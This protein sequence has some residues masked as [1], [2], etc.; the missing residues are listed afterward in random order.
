[1]RSMWAVPKGADHDRVLLCI[2][3]G[4]YIAGSVFTHRKMFA[5]LAKAVGARALILDYTLLPA[6]VFP[7][8]VQEAVAAYR[9]LLEDGI[10]P[11]HIAFTG[12]SAGGG[13][14]ITAQLLARDRGLPLPAAAMPISPW[15]DM[16]VIGETMVSKLGKDALFNQEWIKQL[17]EGYLAGA[18]P[19]DP[20]ATPLCGDLAGLGPM[21]IQVG[22]QELLLDESRRLA[23][24]AEKAGVEVKLD[25]FPGQQHTFQM[26][27]GR[28]PE[29]DEAIRRL[30][31]WARPKLGLG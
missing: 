1:V 18:D 28:A 9:W 6:G 3:G 11:D 31:K 2:H 12:D 20:Y 8:P 21:Y 27:A 29:A 7:R 16:E 24:V 19:R 4:G 5:H 25:V 17:A 22:D 13:L 23:D 30:A 10:F 26:M 14:S 15:V